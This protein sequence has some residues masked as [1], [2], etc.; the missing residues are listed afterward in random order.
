MIEGL[1][2]VACPLRT[3]TGKHFRQKV[4][5]AQSALRGTQEKEAEERR[6]IQDTSL[7]VPFPRVGEG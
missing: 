3:S 7:Q 1:E 6:A 2:A 5:G 4:R